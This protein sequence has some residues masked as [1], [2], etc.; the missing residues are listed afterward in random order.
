[1]KKEEESR[2]WPDMLH[3]GLEREELSYITKV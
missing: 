1:M 2:N 3:C